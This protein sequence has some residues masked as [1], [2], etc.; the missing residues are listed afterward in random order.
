ME[1]STLSCCTSRVVFFLKINM[2]NGNSPT[3]VENVAFHKLIWPQFHL[4]E[5]TWYHLDLAS[6][7]SCGSI[8]WLVG[9][10]HMIH[11]NTVQSG[12]ML[13]GFRFQLSHLLS[14]R[15]R[16]RY[17]ILSVPQIPFWLNGESIWYH[18]STYLIGLFCVIVP[19]S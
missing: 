6:T 13:P 7:V 8:W 15:P 1:L 11:C 4:L 12:T 16:A 14:L 17:L 3:R 18:F 5:G 9:R 2:Q 10:D 19:T